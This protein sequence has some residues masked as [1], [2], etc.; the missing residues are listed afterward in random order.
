MEKSLY[1]NKSKSFLKGSRKE[2][3]KMKE[4]VPVWEKY[5]LTVEEAAAYFNIGE[6]R[7]RTLINEN[8]EAKYILWK[9]TRPNIK[10]KLFENYIDSISMI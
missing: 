6:G 3:N 9:S 4:T 10:R 8:Q 2:K 1:R 7:L 5:T